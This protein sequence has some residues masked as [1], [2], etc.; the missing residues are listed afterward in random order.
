MLNKEYI[1]ECLNKYC[2]FDD[3]L[4]AGNFEEKIITPLKNA[5]CFNDWT[6]DSGLS[7]G[8][9]I[10]GELDYVIK[11]PFSAE[12]IE[13]DEYF[14]ETEDG[15]TEYETC[16][17]CPG[18]LFCG[19]EVEGY[20]KRNSWDYCETEELRYL[21][22]KKNGLA[23]HFAEIVF[24]GEAGGWPIYC[25]ARACMFNSDA[26]TLSRINRTYTENDRKSVE[27][28]QKE[29]GMYLNNE[30]LLDF[31]IFYGNERLFDFLRFCDEQKISDL[32]DGNIGYINGIPCLV[33]YSSYEV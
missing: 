20:S 7:K 18:D 23:E 14:Y 8:V 28:I 33:D 16:G 21:V 12:W 17:G 26:S 6:F 15:T 32:H 25:Q 30:W 3:E 10:F 4:C 22:A 27:T 2:V 19:V 13:E 29:T 1:L 9:L 11:I 31:L 24:L 5:K